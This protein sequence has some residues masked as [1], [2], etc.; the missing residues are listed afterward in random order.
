MG[1]RPGSE[2]STIT[3]FEG[4]IGLAEVHGAGIGFNQGKPETLLHVASVRFMKGRY[5]GVDNR[6]HR[7]TFAF[8]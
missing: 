3:D 4:T 2:P 5:V 6:Q 8:V 7:G 1:A